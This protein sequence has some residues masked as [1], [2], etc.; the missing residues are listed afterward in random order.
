MDGFKVRVETRTTPEGTTLV[1]AEQINIGDMVWMETPSSLRTLSE[2]EARTHLTA[3]QPAERETIASHAYIKDGRLN[4][5][6]DD[7]QHISHSEQPN[8]GGG[9]WPGALAALRSIPAGEQIRE[10]YGTYEQ[11]AWWPALLKV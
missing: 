7:A 11:A 6:L 1:A 10:D 4:I 3:A 5:R 9:K 2:A 8:V